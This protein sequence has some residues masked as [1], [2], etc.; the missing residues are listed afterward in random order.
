MRKN[1]FIVCGVND[2]GKYVTLVENASDCRLIASALTNSR[3]VSSHGQFLVIT[4]EYNNIKMSV[5]SCGLG[6]PAAAI[7]IEELSNYG[8][9][10]IIRAGIVQLYNPKSS[11]GEVIIASGAAKMDGTSKNY[12]LPEFPAVSNFAVN[13]VLEEVAKA[14]KESYTYKIGL[15][16]GRDSYAIQSEIKSAWLKGGILCSDMSTATVLVV[17]RILGIKASSINI[18][19]NTEEDLRICGQLI[20]KTFVRLSEIDL[21][22]TN[23]PLIT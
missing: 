3:V 23:G 14:E 7:A 1:K 12:V 13:L 17:S 15:V 5:C 11:Y 4:G 21:L 6:S 9:K 2:I 22:P 18:V 19:S 10:I 20:L 8:V 16:E